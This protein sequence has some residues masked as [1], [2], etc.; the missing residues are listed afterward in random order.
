MSD[1]SSSWPTGR[2]S[3]MPSEERR[4]WPRHLVQD[5]HATVFRDAEDAPWPV[6]VANLAAGGACLVSERYFAPGTMME[7]RLEKPNTHYCCTV[8][9]EVV[10]ALRHATGHFILGCAFG[11]A[12]TD[13][14]LHGLL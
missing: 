10:Y 2:P 4:R 6:I 11:R 13:N 1:H 8:S 3:G 5:L 14:E 7:A 12:L 9:L